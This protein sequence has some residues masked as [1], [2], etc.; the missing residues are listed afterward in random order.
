MRIEDAQQIASHEVDH[1]RQASQ[2]WQKVEDLEGVRLTKETQEFWVF[3]ARS[4]K[5]IEASHAPGGM[6]VTVDKET[7]H[8]WTPAEIEAYYLRRAEQLPQQIAA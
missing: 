7:G 3:F 2:F 8:I 6:H 4:Q 5:L 1:R